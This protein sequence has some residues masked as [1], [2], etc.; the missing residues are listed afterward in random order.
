MFTCTEGQEN[1]QN[2][3]L[4]TQILLFVILLTSAQVSSLE[5]STH[6]LLKKLDLWL[7]KPT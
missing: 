1:D 3:F 2:I 5:S 4:F 7:K 6:H